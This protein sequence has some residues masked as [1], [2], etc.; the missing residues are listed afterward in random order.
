MGFLQRHLK[1]PARTETMTGDEVV[2]LIVAR[3]E[4]HPLFLGTTA[5]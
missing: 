4:G 2:E 5:V 1:E 3:S